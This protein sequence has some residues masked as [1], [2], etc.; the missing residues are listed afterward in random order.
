MPSDWSIHDDRMFSSSPPIKWQYTFAPM[1]VHNTTQKAEHPVVSVMAIQ[2][3][4]RA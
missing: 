2:E 3:C 4:G 1:Y